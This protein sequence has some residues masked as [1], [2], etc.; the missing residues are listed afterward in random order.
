LKPFCKETAIGGL[1]QGVAL[2]IGDIR[3][4]QLTAVVVDG[5]HP[6]LGFHD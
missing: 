5:F 4:M 1:L 3:T 2:C 6:T